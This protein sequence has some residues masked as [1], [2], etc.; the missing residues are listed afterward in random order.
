[1]KPILP[2]QAHIP[3]RRADYSAASYAHELAVTVVA[4]RIVDRSLLLDTEN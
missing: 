1:M 4:Q 2:G 3:G